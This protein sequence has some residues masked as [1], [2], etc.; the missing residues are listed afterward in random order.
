[1]QNKILSKAKKENPKKKFDRLDANQPITDERISPMLDID[2]PKEGNDIHGHKISGPIVDI[3]EPKINVVK[4]I[5]GPPRIDGPKDIQRP[6]IVESTLDNGPRI[7]KAIDI[8][9]PF[10]EQ[11][12]DN[13]LYFLIKDF[14]SKLTEQNSILFIKQTQFLEK[15]DEKL[16]EFLEKQ[17]EFLEKQKDENKN[18]KNQIIKSIEDLK[19]KWE[20]KSLFNDNFSPIQAR[21]Q[22]ENNSNRSINNN[23]LL[24]F[25]F[26]EFSGK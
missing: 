19:E 2:G 13:Q 3:N 1:M 17:V 9:V 21:N 12:Q 20:K 15:L 7:D 4:D 8:K 14:L 22:N 25:I 6:K 10:H 11:I 23:I 5:Q 16:D 26:T 18:F 24:L